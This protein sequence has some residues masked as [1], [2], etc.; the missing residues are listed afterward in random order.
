MSS[1]GAAGSA[2]VSTALCGAATMDVNSY[3]FRVEWLDTMA[4]LKRPFRLLFFEKRD[5]TTEAELVRRAARGKETRDDGDRGAQTAP[6]PAS[7]AAR[8]PARWP[9]ASSA[10]F[11]LKNK[12]VFLKRIHVP[13]LSLDKIFLGAKLM[14][15]GRWRRGRARPCRLRCPRGARVVRRHRRKGVDGIGGRGVVRR[16]GPGPRCGSGT[17]DSTSS[18]S[19]CPT[20]VSFLPPCSFRPRSFG[21]QMTVVDYEDARTRAALEK[22]QRRCLGLVGAEALSVLGP[23]WSRIEGSGAKVARSKMVALSS[24]DA[25]ALFG[26]PAPCVHEPGERG[27]EGA[28]SHLLSLCPSLNHT[29]PLFSFP[30]FSVFFLVFLLSAFPLASPFCFLAH[31]VLCAARHRGRSVVLELIGEDAAGVW[32]ATVDWAAG[33]LGVPPESLLTTASE[34]LESL[35]AEAVFGT[36]PVTSAPAITALAATGGGASGGA[37]ARAPPAPSVAGSRFPSA[38]ATTATM[39]EC[40]VAIILPHLVASGAAGAALQQLQT[41]TEA[42]GLSLTALQS[43]DLSLVMAEEFYE[44]YRDVVPEFRDMA[45]ELSSG[46]CVVLEFSGPD[47][48][49]TLRTIVGPRDG[50]VAKRI[51]CVLRE[52]GN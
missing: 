22:A 45:A 48:V 9:P 7:R 3:A 31:C 18:S 17:D 34:D 42:A 11:D 27:E 46:V 8:S 40:A 13:G 43:F 4:A 37:S 41:E 24:S 39:R 32:A 6:S 33:E 23:I 26:S 15:Y 28:D 16:E 38:R 12:K 20:R 25:A 52:G 50:D 19:S 44:V 29:P 49:N 2:A 51:R 47:A 14:M 10:Q 35:A 5:G 30:F 1:A 36:S 21:R